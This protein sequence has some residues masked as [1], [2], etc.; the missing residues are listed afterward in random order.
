MHWQLSLIIKKLDR[1]RAKNGHIKVVLLNGERE[2][3]TTGNKEKYSHGGI[4]I[5]KGVIFFYQTR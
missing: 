5:D 3:R 4:R 2:K 1:H